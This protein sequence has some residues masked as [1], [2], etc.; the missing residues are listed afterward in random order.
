[1]RV[2]G[3]GATSD[4]AARLETVHGAR[5]IARAF[6]VDG[7]LSAAGAPCSCE[8]SGGLAFVGRA[9]SLVGYATRTPP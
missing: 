2:R 1:V 5:S 9:G 8:P 7:P 6:G 4:D 3:H